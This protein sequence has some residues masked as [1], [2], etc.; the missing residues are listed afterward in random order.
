MNGRIE[1]TVGDQAKQLLND[2]EFIKKWS[3]LY[4]SCLYG[5]VYQSPDFVCSWYE[6]YDSEWQPVL[7]TSSNKDND[8]TA[9]W[10][11]AF[12][13]KTNTLAHAGTIQAEYHAWL[14][15]PE[16]SDWFIRTAWFA[17]KNQFRFSILKFTYLPPS[18]LHILQSIPEITYNLIVRKKNRPLI[19]LNANEL[20][21]SFMKKKNKSK[22]NHLKKL[23]ELKFLKITELVELER[24]FPEL[25]NYYDFRQGALH[26][27]TPFRDDD[28][29]RSFLTHLFVSAPDKISITV[30]YLNNTPIAAMIG[31]ISNK[32]VHLDLLPSSPFLA[33]YSPGK[34]HLMQLGEYLISQGYQQFDL[35][36]GDDP[37]KERFANA[38][39]E[40]AEVILY[41]SSFLRFFVT[42]FDG[43]KK[44][45][46]P[47][48]SSLNKV[49]SFIHKVSSLCFAKLIYR[50]K[51]W[52]KED[53]EMCIYL[54]ERPSAPSFKSD[55]RVKCNSISDLLHCEPWHNQ[56]VFLSTALKRFNAK[57][58]IYT[59]AIDNYLAIYIWMAKN[60]RFFSIFQ[61][62][63]TIPEKSIVF[64]DASIHPKFRR[65][66]LYKIMLAHMIHEAFTFKDIKSIYVFVLAS[67]LPFRDAIEK[68]GFQYRSSI[69]MRRRFG[70]VKKWMNKPL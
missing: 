11:L 14:A 53:N 6:V 2:I 33:E 26:Q 30:T 57:E 48:K 45:L 13:L 31:M 36:P 21:K 43:L 35:T 20:N 16:V 56:Y 34:L 7:V 41:K 22:L 58:Y 66:G 54:F 63:V 65:N 40:V 8:L 60:C 17:L 4:D 27:V 61:Y 50:I 59:M 64:Y 32:M 23:G 10:T 70:F 69:F 15:V 19:Q 39:D 49:R 1:I 18:L 38:H 24:V 51:N 52:I 46:K 55:E 5:T 29:K 9:L 44:L 3:I 28:K 67:N 68:T 12:S 42:L 25:I 62:S 37:W 47:Y